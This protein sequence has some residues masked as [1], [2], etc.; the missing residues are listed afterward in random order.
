MQR[1]L[2]RPKRSNDEMSQRSLATIGSSRDQ[3]RNC[4]LCVGRTPR[5]KHNS[6]RSGPPL[7]AV[8]DRG[9]SGAND[10]GSQRAP[11]ARGRSARPQRSPVPSG[12]SR[13]KVAVWHWPVYVTL[14]LE[15]DA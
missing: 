11:A 14:A 10:A 9:W 3:V 1:R 4:G 13:D 6:V 8:T 7:F 12:S 2:Q 5:R 15:V